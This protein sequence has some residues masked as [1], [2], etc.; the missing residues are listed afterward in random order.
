MRILIVE[1][2]ADYR[3][4]LSLALREKGHDVSEVSDTELALDAL[5]F[6]E[7]E[8]VLLDLELP[9]RTGFELL[10]EVREAGDEIPMIVVSGRAGVEDRV[11]ALR[12]GADDYLVKP[13]HIEELHARIEAVTR[14]RTSLVPMQFGDLHFDL[15][16]R[17]VT[18][19]GKPCWLS[20]RE[21][22]LLLALARAEGAAVTRRAL[23]Q[24][25]W[26]ISFDPGTNVLDV[27]IGRVRRKIDR[28]G[29]AAIETVRGVGY[30]LNRFNAG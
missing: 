10:H 3:R 5:R 15:A 2:D 6:G 17:R 24:D 28:H 25:V 4:V 13:V 8:L 18:R 14:R 23:L 1:D 7:H 29:P 27:H 19:N 22:D 11:R 16:R 26:D 12:M 20:P 9:E 30:R 21:Y